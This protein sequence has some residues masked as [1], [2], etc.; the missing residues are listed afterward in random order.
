MS[1][2]SPSAKT[3][4]SASLDSIFPTWL[5]CTAPVLAALIIVVTT[6]SGC[7]VG[8]QFELPAIPK[9]AS[10]VDQQFPDATVASPVPGGQAQRFNYGI[11]VAADWWKLFQSPV[12]TQLVDRALANNP[13]IPAAEAALRSALETVAAQRAAFLPTLSLALSPTRQKVATALS[14]PLASGAS[15]YSLHT[16]QLNIAYAVD[17][18]GGNRRQVESLSAQAD[19][20]RFQ[21]EAVRISLTA[22]VV[23]AVV[24]MALLR[25]QIAA[26][27]ASIRLAGEQLTILRK[28]LK[29]GA[30]AAAGVITQEA[31]EAQTRALLPPL[32]KQLAQQQDLLA[33][34]TGSAPNELA[35]VVISLVDLNL[36]L[37]LPVSLPSKLVEQ[38]PDVRAAAEQVQVAS[39][40]V[41]VAIVNMLPQLTL[42]GGLGGAATNVGDVLRSGAGFWS[43]AAGLVQPIFDG[44]AL[45]HKKLSAEANHAQALAQYRGVVLSALQNV[46]DVLHTLRYD[47]EILETTDATVRATL[48]A[49]QIARRQVELGDLSHLNLL[50]FEQT[51]QQNRLNLIQAQ[52]SRFADTAALFQ[53]VGGGWWNRDANQTVSAASPK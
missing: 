7:A 33:V 4:L 40:Q 53:A 16:A 36:P 18:F 12:I 2:F 20:Q 37:D 8:P 52:A 31:L 29:L 25:D 11:D 30:I 1:S 45:L 17:V 3:A 27:E 35:E 41:G 43:I 6:V 44:D 47:A 50:A 9:G 5:G 49:L 22:N 28:Q 39:A 10:Y 42:S 15:V 34:L 51:Y 23:S 32:K 24:Q 48:A 19:Y 46:A 14:P 21:L 26:T 13:T 38:R